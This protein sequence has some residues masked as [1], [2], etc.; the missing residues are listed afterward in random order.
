MWESNRETT[1][2][3]I[4]LTRNTGYYIVFLKRTTNENSIF[5]VFVQVFEI[6][7]QVGQWK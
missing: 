4:V 1:V 3:K 5:Y 6:K 2:Y 7:G